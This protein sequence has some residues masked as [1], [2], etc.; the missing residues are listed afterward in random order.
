MEFRR[1]V[2]DLE[3]FRLGYDEMPRWFQKHI[4]ENNVSNI[5]AFLENVNETIKIKTLEGVMTAVQGDFIIKGVKGEIYP[6]KPQIFRE[7][8][9]PIL[10]RHIDVGDELAGKTLYLDEAHYLGEDAG[11][12]IILDENHKI[13]S[14]DDEDDLVRRIYIYD[15]NNGTVN[16]IPLYENGERVT[17]KIVFPDSFTTTVS[18]IDIKKIGYEFLK[19]EIEAE[20]ELKDFDEEV[21]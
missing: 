3:A 6:C 15:N 8:Y 20:A 5:D 2:V 7:T 21:W 11:D 13:I 9:D 10:L 14:E 1:K 17:D 19:V 4:R 12:I 18:E 16:K